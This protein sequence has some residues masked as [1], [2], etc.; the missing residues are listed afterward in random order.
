MTTA[1]NE[2]YG[3]MNAR[4]NQQNQAAKRHQIF[5]TQLKTKPPVLEQAGGDAEPPTSSVT[6][7]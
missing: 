3:M 4:Y 6:W 5:Q 1:R 7:A 2:Y